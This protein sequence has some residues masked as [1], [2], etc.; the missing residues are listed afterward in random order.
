MICDYPSSIY[1][2]STLFP[3]LTFSLLTPPNLTFLEK[4]NVVHKIEA[5]MTNNDK[6]AM[7]RTLK[8]LQ[9]NGK[10]LALR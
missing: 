4:V 3:C 1:P 2:L 6:N 8:T 9:H 5:G 10:I 7:P